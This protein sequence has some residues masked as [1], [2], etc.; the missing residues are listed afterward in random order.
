MCTRLY[1]TT[2]HQIA[3]TLYLTTRLYWHCIWPLTTRLYWHCIWPDHQIALTLYLT[4]DHQIV[5]TLYLITDHQIVSTFYLTT[6]HQIALTL[7][8]TTDHQIVLTLYLTTD[9]IALTL[10]LT[11]DHQIAL[12]LYLTTDD[13]IVLTTDDQIA[14]TLYVTTDDQIVLTLYLTTDHQ[15]V[16]QSVKHW[17]QDLI[18]HVLQHVQWVQDCICH[19]IQSMWGT[20][21]SIAFTALY[22]LC[23]AV[24]VKHWPVFSVS[25]APTTGLCCGV[26]HSVVKHWPQDC[27][28]EHCSLRESLTTS[29]F[30]VRF[31]SESPAP[32]WPW[33]CPVWCQGDPKD[34]PSGIKVTPKMSRVKETSSTVPW[35][36]SCG[37]SC[38]VLSCTKDWK[39]L[40]DVSFAV[41][42]VSPI[43]WLCQTYR[44]IVVFAW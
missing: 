32:S 40:K 33:R 1:L 43:T 29:L 24:S 39:L 14:L 42:A 11:T 2:D 12:T 26:L 37:E 31:S 10:Y 6:D 44:V 4:T 7:Y 18:C 23:I 8:L 34:V 25:A 15:T 21:D 36:S 17:P 22:L 16:L 3:L 20:D 27:I 41:R 30:C 13:Q 38:Q 35:I 28:T 5:L 9:Q 19:V